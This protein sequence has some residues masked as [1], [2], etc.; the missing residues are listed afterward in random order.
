L[1][2]TRQNKNKNRNT[3]NRK[4]EKRGPN[5]KPEVNTGAGEGLIGFPL[6]VIQYLKENR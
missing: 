1:G 3:E 6:V 4:D 5:Q 2:T